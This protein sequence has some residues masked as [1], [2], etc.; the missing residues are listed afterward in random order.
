MADGP[1]MYFDDAADLSLLAGK[2]IAIIG[3]G[4][5]GRAQA[6]CLRDSGLDVIV[7]DLAGTVNYD[8]A[9][10]DG[11]TVLSADEAA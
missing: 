5:Q 9:V 10:E 11:W 6:L 3:Y 7:S 2:K 4:I 1:Q 8:K